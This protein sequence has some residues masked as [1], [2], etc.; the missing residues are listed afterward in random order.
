MKIPVMERPRGIPDTFEEHAKLMS[1]LMVIA[2]QTDMTRVVTFMMAREGSN[3]SYREIGI[4]G[5][6]PL[7]HPPPERS[8]EDRQDARRSTSSTCRLVLLT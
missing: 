5:R 8:G 1:D 3:R 7:G 6:P 4:S 2:F